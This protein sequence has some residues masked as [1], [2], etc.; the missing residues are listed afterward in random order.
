MYL[1][2]S[3]TEIN[4]KEE[5]FRFGEASL[6]EPISIPSVKKTSEPFP[7][8]SRVIIPGSPG[9]NEPIAMFG[10]KL[11]TNSEAPPTPHLNVT[12]SMG[13]SLLLI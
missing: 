1:R 7:V 8:R 11:T 3:I 5:L 6:E 2:A 4:L 13:I 12:E 10:G 9:G